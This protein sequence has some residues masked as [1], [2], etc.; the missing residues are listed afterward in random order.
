VDEAG[1]VVG[2]Q[3][4]LAGVPGVDEAQ[5]GD[6]HCRTGGLHVAEAGVHG[7]FQAGFDLVEH[8]PHRDVPDAVLVLVVQESG[9]ELVGRDLA[10]VGDD[11]FA[12]D[13]L[14][15][16]VIGANALEILDPTVG[17]LDLLPGLALAGGAHGVPDDAAEER[18]VDAVEQSRLFHG[19]S[20]C[21]VSESCRR[22]LSPLA[23]NMSLSG[24]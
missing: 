22:V 10:I 21:A 17:L 11:R 12:E 20:A 9:G 15:D 6:R 5:R 23:G 7:Q 1:D 13:V 19:T 14:D 3:R 24:S 4:G 8:V 18:A 16:G 2:L